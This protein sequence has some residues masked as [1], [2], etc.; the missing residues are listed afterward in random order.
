MKR[1]LLLLHVSLL[2]LFA[3]SADLR[4]NLAQYTFSVSTGSQNSMVS[5]TALWTGYSGSRSALKNQTASFNIGF[6]FYFDGVAYTQLAA[7]TNGVLSF[8]S[9]VT[10]SATN[11][12]AGASTFPVIAA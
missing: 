12:L 3:A 8:G 6:T 5:A 10:G 7:S 9:S 11:S 4:A 1:L 2:A